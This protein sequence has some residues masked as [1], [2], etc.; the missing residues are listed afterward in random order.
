[1]PMARD[2]PSRGFAGLAK[3][4]VYLKRAEGGLSL[5][6]GASKALVARAERG[7]VG[8]VSGALRDEIE[9][10]SASWVRERVSF[11]VSRRTPRA[12]PEGYEKALLHLAEVCGRVLGSRTRWLAFAAK[13][14]VRRGRAQLPES[15]LPTRAP[16]CGSA[17]R[18]H[19][20]APLAGYMARALLGLALGLA[21][22]AR[23]EPRA[24]G[25]R[26]ALG[27][28]ARAAGK[29]ASAPRGVTTSHRERTPPEQGYAARATPG[30]CARRGARV[31][32]VSPHALR[33]SLGSAHGSLTQ[34]TTRNRVASGA[35][36][37]RHTPAAW[38]PGAAPLGR[39]GWRALIDPCSDER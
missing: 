8:V 12:D 17:H 30:V 9:L 21:P 31:A 35:R 23:A 14:L 5:F 28:R 37:S 34:L 1:L 13:A 27:S 29:R 36:S 19:R 20:E 2:A 16:I 10:G 38:C 39:S 24:P 25:H 15:A 7:P 4:P 26:R 11:V 22:E 18:A 32:L 33:P 6:D 3:R